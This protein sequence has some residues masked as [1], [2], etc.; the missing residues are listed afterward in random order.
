MPA[1]F[2]SPLTGGS[3]RC[4]LACAHARSCS[5]GDKV[6]ISCKLLG[7]HLRG[8]R[9]G[10]RA[11]A[12]VTEGLRVAAER[13]S[14]GFSGAAAALYAPQRRSDTL[15]AGGRGG[16]ARRDPGRAQCA[17]TGALRGP[18]HGAV[19]GRAPRACRPPATG[20]RPG[21]HCCHQTPSAGGCK[22][23]VAWLRW[24]ATLMGS[25]AGCVAV[26]SCV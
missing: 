17:R 10:L 9:H 3:G 12:G 13:L 6:W 2:C 22:L 4:V 26:S 14:S 7:H 21:P 19:T 20:V 15:G 5:Q 11:R 25:Q 18:P 16:G 24:L 23:L 8:S 1:L